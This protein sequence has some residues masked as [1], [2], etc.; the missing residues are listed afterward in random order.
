M[1]TIK[2]ITCFYESIPEPA[3]CKFDS[4]FFS[5][6]RPDF[7]F[8]GKDGSK[9]FARKIF[10]TKVSLEL[11]FDTENETVEIRTPESRKKWKFDDIEVVNVYDDTDG[12]FFEIETSTG[13]YIVVWGYDEAN[14]IAH[15]L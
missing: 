15:F 9:L 5:I 2:N 11:I 13:R 10:G 3:R 12:H 8:L 7:N 4:L 6:N 14:G 1:Q